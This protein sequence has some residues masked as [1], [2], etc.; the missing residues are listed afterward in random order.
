MP[1]GL[2]QE[3]RTVFQEGLSFFCNGVRSCKVT[4]IIN[5]KIFSRDLNELVVL[6]VWTNIPF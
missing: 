1:V 5:I 3:D 2:L 6:S 4:E